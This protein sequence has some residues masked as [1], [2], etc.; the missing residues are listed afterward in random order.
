MLKYNIYNIICM[1]NKM[2][3]NILFTNNAQ[4]Y[5]VLKSTYGRKKKTNTYNIYIWTY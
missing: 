4:K 2:F 1:C 3:N 5:V